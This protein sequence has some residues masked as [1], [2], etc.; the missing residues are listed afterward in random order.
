VQAR[1]HYFGKLPSRGD[2]VRST[3]EPMLVQALDGWMSQALV[4]LRDRAHWQATYDAAAPVQFAILGTRSHSGLAGHLVTSHDSAGR[5]FPFVMAATFELPKP[6]A[7][8]P[9]SPVALCPLWCRLGAQVRLAQEAQDF[10]LVQGRLA[11]LPLAVEVDDELSEERRAFFLQ[12]FSLERFES[13]VSPPEDGFSMRQTLLALG[14]LLRP[15]R[16]RGPAQLEKAL[17]LPLPRDP[18]PRPHVLTLWVDLVAG[19]FKGMPVEM[20]LFVTTHGDQ[21]VLVVGF[22]GAAPATLRSVIDPEYCREYN[23]AVGEAK[24]V[25]EVL[26]ADDGLRALS[27]RLRDSSLSLATASELFRETFLDDRAY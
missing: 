25:E 10:A 23:V 17:V 22:H 5:R 2:F 1:S 18:M 27:N 19:F 26:A 13:V 3:A 6:T 4:L 9:R 14:L 16:S 20:A 12:H 24:W 11:H 7:F 8:L 21:P 15:V